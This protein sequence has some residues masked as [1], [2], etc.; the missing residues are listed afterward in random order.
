M[1][2]LL[3]T[4]SGKKSRSVSIIGAI[5]ALFAVSA[6]HAD[7]ERRSLLDDDPEVVY[8]KDV[9][10]EPLKLEVIKEA[11]VY[12]DREGN[13]KLGTIK[14]GQKVKIEAITD[15]IYRIRSLDFRNGISGWVGPWAFK[16][17]DPKFA[18]NLKQLYERQ[19]LVQKLIAE[20]KVAIG[21]TMEEVSKSRGEPTKT[22][23]RKTK[24]GQVGS[25]EYI[26]YDEEKNYITKTD[27]R[28]G[29]IY[30]EL[31]SVTQVEKGKTIIEFEGDTVTA[32]EE[33]EH[34]K[35]G[36]LRIIVPPIV[37]GW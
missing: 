3:C 11:P 8:L 10:E 26:D 18:E 36:D 15:K 14:A 33:S 30:R 13:R 20:K 24:E 27:P 31:V 17:K 25:W 9:F 4:F 1:K 35:G 32:L 2:G 23:L 37:C 19:I 16:A 21:M 34:R 29:F 22:S 28:T 6:L 5:C 7:K 12:S